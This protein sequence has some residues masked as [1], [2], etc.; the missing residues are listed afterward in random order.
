MMKP[1]RSRSN[2]REAR[3]GSLLRVLSAFMA[4]NPARPIST[5]DA[6]APPARK[7]SAS[8]DLIMRQDSPIALFD[9]AQA[10]TMHKLGP[11]RL[12]SIEMKPLAM[13]LIS[14]GIVNGEF[15]DGPFVNK[16]VN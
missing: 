8:P 10:V 5:M 2:G 15:R 3:S 9:V 7:T 16:I 11:W 14:I 6:S 4:E 1:S 12:N 13:L